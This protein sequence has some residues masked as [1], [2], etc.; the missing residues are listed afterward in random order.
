MN[1][2]F[3]EQK[4]SCELAVQTPWTV[5]VKVRT[6]KTEPWDGGW[7]MRDSSFANNSSSICKSLLNILQK[8]I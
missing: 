2:T 8:L 7:G 1:E 6:G 4:Q 3:E 5:S